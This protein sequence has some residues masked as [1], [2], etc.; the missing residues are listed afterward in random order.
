[1]KNQAHR[2]IS[3]P[4]PCF[5]DWDN[6]T[7]QE[8]GRHCMK[9]NKVVVDFT[10][11]S[12]DELLNYIK[13]SKEGV[14]GRV[15]DTQIHQSTPTYK[16]PQKLKVFLYSLAMAFLINIPL[17]TFAQTNIDTTIS[18]TQP[19]AEISGYVSDEKG[20]PIKNAIIQ[21]FDTKGK[22]LEAVNSDKRGYY[23]IQAIPFGEHKIVTSKIGFRSKYIT[24]F[25]MEKYNTIKLNFPMYKSFGNTILGSI[26]YYENL[27]APSE[28]NKII[29]TKED[30]KHV[31]R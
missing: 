25:I 13:N 2:Y 1:M 23:R 24:I 10:S 18:Q 16:I 29:M 12:D 14:C 11:M 21:I 6:M 22:S 4:T 3:I 26:M 30:L 28:P 9:C 17:D 5:E 27:I 31:T 7:P 15:K 8:K 19:Y 20:K